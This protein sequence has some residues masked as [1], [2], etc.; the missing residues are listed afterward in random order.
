MNLPHTWLSVLPIHNDRT[1]TATTT[2]VII[3]ITMNMSNNNWQFKRKKNAYATREIRSD[4]TYVCLI[5]F[6]CFAPACMI[7]E[8]MDWVRPDGW[9]SLYGL[10]HAHTHIYLLQ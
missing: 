4:T 8:A 10:M 9:V 6:Y 1:A 3:I 7:K 2:T 5:Q